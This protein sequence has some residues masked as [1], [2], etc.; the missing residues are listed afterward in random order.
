VS[1]LRTQASAS[2]AGSVAF[3]GDPEN[4]EVVV[5]EH[6]ATSG[7]L[8][9]TALGA[10][11]FTLSADTFEDDGQGNMVGKALVDFEVDGQSYQVKLDAG[12]YSAAGVASTLTSAISAQTSADVAVTQAGTSLVLTSASTGA[13]SNVRASGAAASTL[14][15][16]GGVQVDGAD[17]YEEEVEGPAGPKS[18]TYLQR[19]FTMPN[20]TKYADAITAALGSNDLSAATDLAEEVAGLM[21]SVG[22]LAEFTKGRLGDDAA[23]RTAQAKIWEDELGR[24]TGIDVAAETANSIKAQIQMQQIAWVLAQQ[25]NHEAAQMRILMGLR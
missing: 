10:G 18:V 9:G 14:G 3:S 21:E 22:S 15:L 19:E 7:R 13:T 12:S 24:L 23:A 1:A 25:S 16:A 17:A 11:T 4:P 5:I 2:F 20:L 8:T 6:A